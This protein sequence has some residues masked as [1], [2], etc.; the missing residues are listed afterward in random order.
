MHQ[1]RIVAMTRKIRLRINLPRH[2]QSASVSGATLSQAVAKTGTPAQEKTTLWT[3][4]KTMKTPLSQLPNRMNGKMGE[5]ALTN[6]PYT[7]T[8]RIVITF[9]SPKMR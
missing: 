4:L 9:H 1:K 7:K 5:S 8:Q 3:V 2:N 6:R